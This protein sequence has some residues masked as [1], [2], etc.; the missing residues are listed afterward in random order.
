M[1]PLLDLYLCIR[2]ALP[3][4][5]PG[6]RQVAGLLQH[7]APC[8]HEC[9]YSPLPLP[10]LRVSHRTPVAAMAADAAP[11]R[12]GAEDGGPLSP[13]PQSHFQEASCHVRLS[14]G[15]SPCRKWTLVARAPCLTPSYSSGLEDHMDHMHVGGEVVDD[16]YAFLGGDLSFVVAGG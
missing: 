1:P 12:C 8:R 6:T 11:D 15:I 3:V 13:V 14:E 7:T 10:P 2:L 4:T 16:C 5:C 9:G